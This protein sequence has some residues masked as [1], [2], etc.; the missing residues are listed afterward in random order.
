[1]GLQFFCRFLILLA[2]I[3]S[4][5]FTLS[6]AGADFESRRMLPRALNPPPAPHANPNHSP[7]H[8]RR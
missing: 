7:G 6:T 3:A 1:M 8:G 2:L 4:F 5:S